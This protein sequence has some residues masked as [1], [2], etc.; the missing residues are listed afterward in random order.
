MANRAI[1]RHAIGPRQD[2]GGHVHHAR[3]VGANIA[4][5]V[6]E[7]G[8]VDREDIAVAIDRRP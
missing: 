8:I 5:L 7:I 2:A 4:A 1:G 6:M 3:R